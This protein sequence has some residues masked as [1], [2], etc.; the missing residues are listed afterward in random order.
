LPCCILAQ[1]A[2]GL[3]PHEQMRTHKFKATYT[4]TAGGDVVD[5]D[6]DGGSASSGW[7]ETKITWDDANDEW[8]KV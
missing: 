2:K 5:G 6:A 7:G 3:A 1:Q 8:V 4:I